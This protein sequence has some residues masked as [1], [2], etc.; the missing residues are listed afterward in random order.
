MVEILCG[1]YLSCDEQMV[2]DIGLVGLC[3]NIDSF[4]KFRACTKSS[5]N[6]L[7][8]GVYFEYHF[9]AKKCAGSTLRIFSGL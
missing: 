5:F 6:T 2:E 9:L 8:N 7:S 4:W 3:T 1:I